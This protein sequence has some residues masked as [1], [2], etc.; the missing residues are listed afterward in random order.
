MPQVSEASR[1]D[2]KVRKQVA[3][4]VN[5]THEGAM[6]I[7]ARSFARLL[8]EFDIQITYR[9]PN[10]VAAIGN[11]LTHLL[12]HHP[13]TVYVLDMSYSGVIA[14]M[15]YALMSGARLV[16][17]TGDA[18]GFLADSTGERG[19]LG[20]RLTHLLEE[21][22]TRCAD[23]L[24]VRSHF[25]REHL[26]RK[27]RTV[28]A[29][30]DGVDVDEFAPVNTADL[31]RRLGFG[32]C[33]TVGFVG[34]ITWNHRWQICYGWELVEAL[35]HLRD[36]PVK[37][38]VIGDGNGLEKLKQMAVA[39][40]VADRMIFAGRV[41]YADLPEY[42]AGIDVCLS[43]QSNDLAGQVRTTG[44]LPLYLASGRYVLSTRVGE[45]ARVLP[46][47]MLLE[48]EGTKDDSYPVRLAAKIRELVET[49][50]WRDASEQVRN[51]AGE[52]FDYERLAPHVGS[53]ILSR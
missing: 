43:T 13:A 49:G 2:P 9:K 35:A 12:R 18:I 3:F 17:D 1:S 8:N 40:G 26:G 47:A 19:W 45:A 53:A 15:L 52:N 20:R 27:A 36:L 5:G 37:G 16:I 24:V 10:K 21:V 25:H 23:A 31:R 42:L 44:K 38:V 29:V 32:D 33:V 51:I 4:L 46:H 39:Q 22:S 50:A 14:G 41:P 7:R 34:S 48:Y 11:F 6:G 28:W 30:P